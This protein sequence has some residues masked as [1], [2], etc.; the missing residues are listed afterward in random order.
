RENLRTFGKQPH[1][2]SGIRGPLSV[3]GGTTSADRSVRAAVLLPGEDNRPPFRVAAQPPEWQQIDTLNVYGDGSREDLAGTLTSTALTGLNMGSGLDF[4]NLLCPNLPD[5]S[6]C[7]H[8]F[9][10]PGIYPGGVS[11]G[12]IS[13]DSNGVFSTD[14]TLS[15]IEIVNVMLGAGNDRLDIQSTLQPGGD[16]NPITGARGELAHH[17][18][19]TAV[20]GG[21]NALLKVDGIF[22]LAAPA[23]A[24]AGTGTVAQITRNDGLGWARVGFAVG[25]QVTLANGRSY[26]VTGFTTTTGKYG[27]G[28]TMFLG[29]G[30]AVGALSTI[31]GEVAVSDQLAVTSTFTL[32]GNGVLLTSGQAWQS[33]GFAVG[34]QVYI[35]GQGVRTITGFANDPSTN[36]SDGTPRD[37]A[38]LLVDGAPLTGGPLTATISLT[39]RYRLT[40]TIALLGSAD[41]GIVTVSGA[42]VAGSGLAVGQ[43]IWITG[44][45]NGPRTISAINGNMLTVTD[46]PI[47]TTG[48]TAGA[49]SLVRIGGDTIKLTGPTFTGNVSTTPTTI[50]RA[51]GSWIADGFAIGR[52]IVLG[53]G[54]N[55]TFNITNV[56][57]STLTIGG[58]P[59][60]VLTGLLTVTVLPV[61]AGPGQPYD[62]Y[63][64]LVIYGDTSQDGVWYGG[65][66][67][68]QS[69]HNF[70]P[71]PM[72]HIEATTVT[73]ARSADGWTGYITL[74][75]SLGTSS[76]DFRSDG[77]AVG[78]EVAL[79]PASSPATLANA[80][81]YDIFSNHLTRHSG[82]WVADGFTVGQQ[83]TIGALLGTWTVAGVSALVLDLRGP[84][85]TPLPNQT[86]GVTAVSQYIGIVKA[87][88]KTQI[89]LN[90]AIG[91]A[92]FP[93]G[94]LFPV[95]AGATQ[96][97]VVR[98]LRVLNRV[99]NSAPFFVF[100][101]ANPY[102]YSG[103]DV[104]DARLLDWSANAAALRSVGVT[105]YGG[106]GNDL[107]VGSQTGDHLAGGSGDDTIM[108]QRGQD[109][110]YGDS[111]FNVDLIT[112]S[113]VV[114]VSG[115]G[116]AGYPAAQFKNKDGLVAG[117]DLLYG[118]GPGSAT[119][120]FFNTVGNDDDII[121]GDLGVVTQDVAGPRDVTK[122]VPAKPQKIA[123]T[124]IGDQSSKLND[125][126]GVVVPGAVPVLVSIGVLNVDSKALQ[127]GAN[128]WLYGNADRDLLVGGTGDDAI[129]GGIQDDLIF[130]DNVATAR[131]Y[132][133]YTSPHFQALTGTLLYGRSDR[134]PFPGTDASGELLVDNAARNYR[135]TNDI[136][137]WAEYDVS[138][139]WHDLA[140]DLGLHWAGSFGD[141]YVAGNQGN[142][143]ALGQLGDD[144]LQGDGS[145]DYVSPGSPVPTQ[146]V[147]AF[148]TPGTC[149]AVTGGV[150]CDPVGP[151]TTYSSIE[152]V[153][154][155]EDYIEGNGGDDVVFGGLGQDDI[156]GGSS[157]FFSL[158]T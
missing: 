61:G 49:I 41:G 104:I 92:D 110:I 3:E 142:D 83:V 152:R 65:N 48:A 145:I 68:T 140:A 54:T 12:S 15:T 113:L 4:S 154:D 30:T 34:Q 62:A 53:A 1:L 64:P 81:V 21:G 121:F 130:G 52:Q 25:Q 102:L 148:R 146:R 71:K 58:S 38:I 89:T 40:G 151:L 23:G 14:G 129:D 137:W 100:P 117:A 141:D 31:S 150:L 103:N 44:V 47:V 84:T 108:G 24:P 156:A 57:A 157:S 32:A 98:D 72:P 119:P 22:D 9:S 128:D 27:P 5:R 69:L 116:P 122:P 133:D 88:T 105:I 73:L 101:L 153:T 78:Q 16:F 125:K 45:N 118:E 99:G 6:T 109:H 134:A 95:V 136:P 111:G 10:E 115:N 85:L 158:A 106:P 112:R 138:E 80:T 63:A 13:I 126:Y 93:S 17:G 82:S 37:G 67:H 143:V 33:L 86:A 97:N 26:T 11:Y 123:T 36:P 77:F 114:A 8:P 46:G 2:L 144:T 127:N 96:A 66:P 120:V 51:A 94:P 39:S 59:L 132:G 29:G 107:I 91:V 18:G 131:T 79:G 55:A 35:P 75:G 124:S 139:L 60:P 147:G 70:G 135:D 43:Q 50:T 155:G 20:H 42:S 7:K 56:T 76:G 87:V 28:D 74:G 90:L 149:V 19:I